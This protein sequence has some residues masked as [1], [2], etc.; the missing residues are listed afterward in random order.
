VTAASGSHLAAGLFPASLLVV[1]DAGAGGQH[2][3][4]EL[5]AARVSESSERWPP[6]T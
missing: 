2:D 5:Q 4:A 1:H 3:D 6:K